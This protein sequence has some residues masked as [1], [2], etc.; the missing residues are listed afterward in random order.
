MSAP[1]RARIERL[2]PDGPWQWYGNT[3]HRDIYLSTVGRG[4]LFVMRFCRWGMGEAQPEF[5]NG[6]RQSESL[7]GACTSGRA[8]EF[9]QYE[10][11][12]LVGVRNSGDPSLYRH[13]FQGIAHPVARLLSAAPILFDRLEESARAFDQIAD[14]ADSPALRDYANEQ[15]DS[16]R[17][18]LRSLVEGEGEGETP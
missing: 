17:A 6:G 11:A 13:C 9:V 3:K 8:S 15:A 7:G 2:W 16:I 10:V 5:F 1:N 18:Y 4:R 14:I 12:P